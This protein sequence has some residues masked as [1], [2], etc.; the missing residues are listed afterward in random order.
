MDEFDRQ[1]CAIE[2]LEHVVALNPNDRALTGDAIFRLIKL[3]KRAGQKER[4]TQLIRRYWELGKKSNN[5]SVLSYGVRSFPP[6]LTTLAVFDIARLQRSRMVSILGEGML[7]YRLTCDDERKEVLEFEAWI[8]ASAEN[9]ALQDLNSEALAAAFE[10]AREEQREL[11]QLERQRRDRGGEPLDRAVPIT[12]VIC[13]VLSDLGL[14]SFSE[15]ERV[16]FAGR[17][18][19][20][21][22]TLVSIESPGVATLLA[23]AVSNGVLT[24]NSSRRWTLTNVQ[25]GEDPVMLVQVD[26]DEIIVT[27]PAMATEVEQARELERA[28]WSPELKKLAMMVPSDSCFFFIAN[29]EVLRWALEHAGP[30]TA[31]LPKPQ[32]LV[33]AA[34]TY[35]HTGF[36]VRLH[37]AERF[38]ASALVWLAQKIL[39]G[40]EAK[41]AED[42]DR[43]AWIEDMDVA[44]A[45]NGGDVIFGVTMS[46]AQARPMF[47]P[48][49]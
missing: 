42:S 31:L 14:S 40:E 24:Q 20:A 35:E 26:S 23:S 13:D 7:E 22:R 49:W 16:T 37:T 4:L 5:A 27:R 11:Q 32:G 43:P 18:D 15:L 2:N 25:V 28:T 29:E 30:L 33:A 21:T 41:D 48:S 1:D 36:F 6:D 17:H 47:E 8:Q 44:L 38:K 46:P 3:Y 39:E 10:V 34:A 45:P 9:P 12:S 19:D